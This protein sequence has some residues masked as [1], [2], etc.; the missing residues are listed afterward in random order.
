MLVKKSVDKK[1]TPLAQKSNN[2][3]NEKDTTDSDKVARKED[4][5]LEKKRPNLDHL[6]GRKGG[7]TDRS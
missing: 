1:T 5:I 4:R 6:G 2:P 3:V 7:D